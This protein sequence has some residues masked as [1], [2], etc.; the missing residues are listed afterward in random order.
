MLMIRTKRG[1]E[2]RVP[3]DEIESIAEIEVDTGAERPIPPHPFLHREGTKRCVA[4]W[5]DRL[6]PS[7]TS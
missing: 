7:H 4:C 5:Q 6:H 3:L 2:I 1:I